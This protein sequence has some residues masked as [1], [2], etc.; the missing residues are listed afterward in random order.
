M[1]KVITFKLIFNSKD[2]YIYSQV[3]N[4]AF[5]Y[6]AALLLLHK[7]RHQEGDAGPDCAGDDAA[8]AV[9]DPQPASP[10]VTPPAAAQGPGRGGGAGLRLQCQEG[11]W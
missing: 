9:Y 8:G 4:P 2:I 7:Q 10:G 5:L 1:Q 3:K 6:L 11:H